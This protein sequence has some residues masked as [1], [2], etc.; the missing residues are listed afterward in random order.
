MRC[1]P[2]WGV[3]QFVAIVKGTHSRFMVFRTGDSR[4]YL[5]AQL[6]PHGHA[7]GLQ[8]PVRKSELRDEVRRALANGW[9]NSGLYGERE[10]TECP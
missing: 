10:G 7:T 2:E 3:A 8:F 5:F 9:G 6:D 1:P 4:F